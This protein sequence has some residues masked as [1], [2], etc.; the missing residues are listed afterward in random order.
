MKKNREVI[1]LENLLL[2]F[3][4]DPRGGERNIRDGLEKILYYYIILYSLYL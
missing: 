4:E 3:E 1:V 2:H